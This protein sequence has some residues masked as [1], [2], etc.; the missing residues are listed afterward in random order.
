MDALSSL[1]GGKS[2][3]ELFQDT[4]N[5]WLAGLVNDAFSAFDQLMQN[6]LES[7]FHVENL[8]TSGSTTV[9]TAESIHNTYLFIYFFACSLIALKFLF[10]GF[11]VYILWRDG[12]ADAS[13]RDMLMGGIQAAVVMV[14]FPFLYEYLA[15]I[16]IYLAEGIMGQLGVSEGVG[17]T[18]LISTITTG[19][20]FL[21]I[22]LVV[23]AI[24]V[25]I[26]WIRL[27]ARGC[28]LLVLRLGIPIACV[29]LIDSDMGLFR[30]YLQ[31]FF[32][33]AFTAI[34][35]VV[36]M[37]LS[38]RV[39]AN[40]NL[41][42]MMFAI[43]LLTMA[44]TTPLLMQQLLAASHGGGGMTQKMYSAGMLVRSARMIFRG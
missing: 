43:A 42:S 21:L 37:S 28:E 29:G 31:L 22:L 20:V 8:V 1:L 38:F 44:F 10:K 18:T 24:A 35:Q 25:L 32:K 7:V 4:I 26:L 2:L 34:I 19:G 13:P 30:G 33:A 12:D 14:S 23:Y 39:A 3:L 41:M 17:F 15:G 9:L 6:L 36:L 11:Q 40:A 5:G 27:M 16:S